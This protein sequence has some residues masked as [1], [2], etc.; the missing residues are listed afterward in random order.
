MWM[1]VSISH[2]IICMILQNVDDKYN[3]KKHNAISG[4]IIHPSLAQ[5]E[6]YRD[7]STSTSI[8]GRPGL[9]SRQV[10]QRHIRC[11][12]NNKLYTPTTK[13]R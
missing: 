10:V 8:L 9:V 5:E 13:T 7:S 12:I 3:K 6:L 1:L 4:S 11:R 2:T